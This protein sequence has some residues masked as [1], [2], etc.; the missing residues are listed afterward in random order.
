MLRAYISIV[1]IT[2]LFS[3]QAMEGPDIPDKYNPMKIGQVFTSPEQIEQIGTLDTQHLKS[4]LSQIRRQQGLSVDDMRAYP[5]RGYTH[6]IG[7]VMQ[8]KLTKREGRPYR[9]VDVL[10]TPDERMQEAIK[11]ELAGRYK[12]HL[13][14]KGIKDVRSILEKLVSELKVNPAFKKAIYGFK[15]ATPMP[16]GLP[17]D[18]TKEYV[19]GR[20]RGGRIP[21]LIV[22]Y[23]SLGKENAQLVL[24]TLYEL[25]KD[26]P[27]MDLAPDYNKKITSLIYV[28]QG[29]A[30]DKVGNEQYFGP[31][32]VYYKEELIG[33]P[34]GNALKSPK[35]VEF[36]PIG[37]RVKIPKGKEFR[38]TPGTIAPESSEGVMA[39]GGGNS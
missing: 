25:F 21:G 2:L 12:I 5:G 19:S 4:W 35:K 32:G 15:I 18:L 1:A 3:V 33:Q 17:D 27:G 36:A 16:Y 7:D 30:D 24:D 14:P 6:F 22:V 20:T 31:G 23:P 29:D 10:R 34:G 8:G 39:V 9:L 26:M 37:R 28:A 38:Y 13:M 11:S